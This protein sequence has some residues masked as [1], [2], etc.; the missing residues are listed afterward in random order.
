MSKINEYF[1]NEQF[2]QGPVVKFTRDGKIRLRLKLDP[3]NCDNLGRR[4]LGI[5]ISN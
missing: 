4:Q 5:Y 2:L 3:L 1:E